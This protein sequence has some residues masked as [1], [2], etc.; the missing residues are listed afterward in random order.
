MLCIHGEHELKLTLTQVGTGEATA[1]LE[2]AG[3]QGPKGFF[4]IISRLY[5]RLPPLR[6]R[7]I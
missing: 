3:N 1:G 6:R 5:S 7:F 4:K 2:D